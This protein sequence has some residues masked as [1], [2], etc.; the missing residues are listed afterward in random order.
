M[1]NIA[2]PADNATA[3]R[4]RRQRPDTEPLARH[5][6]GLRRHL[7][8]IGLRAEAAAVATDLDLLRALR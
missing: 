1:S 8:A 5:L 6:D 3:P 2:N 4:R 7:E